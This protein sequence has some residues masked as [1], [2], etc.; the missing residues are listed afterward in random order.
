MSWLIP[1]DET[2]RR[3]KVILGYDML[4][5]VILLCPLWIALI[6]ACFMPVIHWLRELGQ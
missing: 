6:M 2:D 3:P 4:L 5:Y 1:D